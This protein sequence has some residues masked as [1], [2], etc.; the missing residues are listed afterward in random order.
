MRALSDEDLKN[1]NILE[2]LKARYKELTG[3]DLGNS[4]LQES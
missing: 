1:T 2:T 3:I 4:T